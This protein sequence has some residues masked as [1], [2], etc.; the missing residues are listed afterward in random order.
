MDICKR[1]RFLFDLVTDAYQQTHVLRRVVRHA[2][3]EGADVD[4]EVRRD[5]RRVVAA[6][7]DGEEGFPLVGVRREGDPLPLDH[8]L[9]PRR[10]LLP[11][12]RGE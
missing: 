10:E 6:A 4:V 12:G 3:L 5:A 8:G 7:V 2:E 9:G 1:D 11:R